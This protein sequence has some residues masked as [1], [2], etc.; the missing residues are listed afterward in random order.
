MTSES[1]RPRFEPWP[2]AVAGTLCAMAAVL[3]TL[4]WFAETYPV[5]IV[6]DPPAA[7]QAGEPG[8][9]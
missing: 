5:E 8:A 7:L 9:R 3:G 6:R 2:W 1:T 4:L